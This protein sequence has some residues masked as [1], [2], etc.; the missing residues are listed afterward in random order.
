MNILL[1]TCSCYS[2][3]FY[4][5]FCHCRD[6]EHVSLARCRIRRLLAWFY[7]FLTLRFSFRATSSFR[8]IIGQWWLK[9][10]WTV[11]AFGNKQLRVNRLC[12]KTCPR[13]TLAVEWDIKPYQP[14]QRPLPGVWSLES[15]GLGVQGDSDSR[16]ILLLGC[17][18]IVQLRPVCTFCRPIVLSQTCPHCPAMKP[19][20]ART[21]LCTFC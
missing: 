11:V 1:S 10:G 20:V 3:W 2:L 17:T 7:L 19:I 8:H 4:C 9:C 21:L 18:M 12:I 13:V 5:R 15:L 14:N 16:H 6:T